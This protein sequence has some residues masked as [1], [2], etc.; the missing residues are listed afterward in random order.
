MPKP[1]VAIVG[2]PN[3]GKST[4]FNRITGQR[5]AIVEDKPGVTRDR[6]YQE[7][8]WLNVKFT[9]IDT[10]GIKWDK[11]SITTQVKK[12]AELAI[13]EAQVIIFLTDARTGIVSDDEEVADLLRK[14]GKPV[15]LAVNKVENFN[16]QTVYEFYSLG[17]GEPIPISASH[18]LN[19]GDLLDQV[20]DLLP[21]KNLFDDL[22]DI[23]KV[24]V[25]GRPNVG[26]SS[27][28]NHLLGEQRV[29]VSDIP[30]TTRDA[31]DTTFVFENQKY[32]LIDTAGIRKRKK[33]DDPVERYSVI[34]S[35]QAIERADVV[36]LLID[37]TDG[38]TEQDTKIAG[39]AHE[40][41]KAV[42]IVVNKWDLIE[43]DSKTMN[44]FDKD[45][46]NQLSYMQYAPIIYISAL[47]GQRVLK[48][49]ELVNFVLEQANR[50]I[51]TNVINRLM[52]EIIAINPP[53]TDKGKKLKILYTTQVSIK[54][55]T[56]VIFVNDPELM[57]FSYQ[58]HIENQFRKAFGFEG[59]PLRFIIR[60]R[61]EKE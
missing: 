56:F 40:E 27:L 3:V 60:Q 38:V 37:A 39:Y 4:L 48:I 19:I 35:L 23:V 32:L 15:V 54:P 58:R 25:V 29:I 28:V 21:Q 13:D 9:L 41:G 47:T 43:K 11:D 1:I 34:R 14:S 5:I 30:G 49:L 44:K 7:A 22:E 20:I 10:G 24:A 52:E 55:P 42:I 45:I 31:V 46:R 36:L 17:L 50:R 2:R 12:Q 33:I 59:N 6:L 51:P 16:E 26:K 53:P 8:E 61:A 57:H 18:G